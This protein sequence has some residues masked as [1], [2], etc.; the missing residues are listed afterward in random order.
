MR[1]TT[2]KLVFLASCIGDVLLGKKNL[3]GKTDTI[4]LVLGNKRYRKH[5]YLITR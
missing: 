3:S 5:Q 4:G 1:I 2:S